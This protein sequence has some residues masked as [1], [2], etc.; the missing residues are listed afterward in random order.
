MYV[1]LGCN[2]P[3]NIGVLTT[4]QWNKSTRLPV[5]DVTSR[6]FMIYTCHQILVGCSN[7]WQWNEQ[8]IWHVYRGVEKYVQ[9][10]E[11]KTDHL[12]DLDID[13]DLKETGMEGVEWIHLAQDTDKW[14]GFCEH[15][16]ELPGFIQWG[17]FLAWWTTCF[18]RRT[19]LHEV[20]SYSVSQ[21]L[22]FG[23]TL[24]LTSNI[25]PA[26]DESIR[27][28]SCSIKLSH[29]HSLSAEFFGSFCKHSATKR[30][31]YNDTS[32]KVYSTGVNHVSN[33]FV[34]ISVSCWIKIYCCQANQGHEK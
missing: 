20:F 15:G 23:G 30:P 17:K 2:Q 24:M 21:S 9:D 29:C 13:M 14:L 1:G 12:K 7:Q 3:E 33:V 11:S 6:R 10:L 22:T 19:L 16:N 31:D 4:K 18:S 27:Y 25:W 32:R 34:L 28:R 5:Q 26:C 8:S